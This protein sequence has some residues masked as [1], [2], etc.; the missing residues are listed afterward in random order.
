MW[1][2]IVNE[3]NE[4]VAFQDKINDIYITLSRKIDKIKEFNLYSGKSGINL[5]F[6]YYQTIN[7]RCQYDF[8]EVIMSLLTSA[9]QYNINKMT[10]Y[11]FLSLFAEL[12]WFLCHLY[13]KKMINIDLE[14][15]FNDIDESLCEGMIILLNK[16]EYGCINGAISFAMIFYYRYILGDEK[17]KCYL[18]LF[19]ELLKK[20]H[21]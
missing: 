5:F 4:Q 3:A 15:Y 6:V 16:N 8:E 19:V 13:E 14:E 21:C 9:N 7:Q 17:C 11:K 1:K 10:N 12:F 20:R 2:L 18:E